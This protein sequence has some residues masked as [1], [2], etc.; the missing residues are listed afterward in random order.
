VGRVCGTHGRGQKCVE[1]FGR[2]ATSKETTRKI[3]AYMRGWD[4]NGSLGDWLGG[5]DRIRMA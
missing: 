2:K 3:K 4:Q 1:G 5:V